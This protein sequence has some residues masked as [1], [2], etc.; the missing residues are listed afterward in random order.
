MKLREYRNLNIILNRLFDFFKE[1]NLK[2]AY[3]NI[4]DNDKVKNTL[5]DSEF[6]RY[7]FHPSVEHYSLDF[8][9]NRSVWENFVDMML[10]G[11]EEDKNSTSFL[12]DILEKKD[13][14]CSFFTLSWHEGKYPPFINDFIDEKGMILSEGP[15]GAA[16]TRVQKD[17][18]MSVDEFEEYLKKN[19]FEG[20]LK[21]IEVD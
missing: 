10:F 13:K 16:M 19:H 7:N 17:E 3:G 4:V 21:I 1:M 15:E 6:V 2:W 12:I 5:L 18:I 14:D 8:K 9:T 11:T 20:N